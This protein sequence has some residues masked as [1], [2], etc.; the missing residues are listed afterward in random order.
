[1][2]N[3]YKKNIAKNMEKKATLGEAAILNELIKAWLQKREN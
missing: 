2:S 3:S 1:L